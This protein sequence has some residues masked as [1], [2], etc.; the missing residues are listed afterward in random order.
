MAI[1]IKV[2]TGGVFGVA[3]ICVL[4]DEAGEGGVIVA[5]AKVIQPR[6]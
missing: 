6:R 2:L 5:G 4:A 3:A 1:G